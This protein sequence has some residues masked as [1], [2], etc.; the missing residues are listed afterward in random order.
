MA[1]YRFRC[2]QIPG[3]PCKNLQAAWKDCYSTIAIED[4]IHRLH[5]LQILKAYAVLV[6]ALI[7]MAAD[8]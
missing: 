2:K 7:T 6:H 8:V 4:K 3:T 5:V 1:P